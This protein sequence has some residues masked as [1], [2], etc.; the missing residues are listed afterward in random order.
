[1]FNIYIL[2]VLD[3]CV[4]YIYVMHLADAFSQSDLHYILLYIFSMCA[5][6]DMNPWPFAMFYH[7][8]QEH[9]CSNIQFTIQCI[10]IISKIFLNFHV[11]TMYENDYFV[12]QN[13]TY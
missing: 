9:T 13:I 10:Q 7:E 4:I 5:P 11:F 2:N 8:P 1:M 3:Y 6:W 12:N